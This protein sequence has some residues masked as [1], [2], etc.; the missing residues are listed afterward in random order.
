MD[1]KIKVI[2]YYLPQYHPLKKT[3]SGGVKV[4]QNGQM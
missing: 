4:L 2:A 1:N 3:M